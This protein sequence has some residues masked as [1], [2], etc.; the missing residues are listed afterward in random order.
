MR[1]SAIRKSARAPF[2]LEVSGLEEFLHLL[3]LK[4]REPG[5]AKECLPRRAVCVAD[6]FDRHSTETGIARVKRYVRAS[7]AFHEDLISIELLSSDGFEHP[8]P[9]EVRKLEEKHTRLLE[10]VRDTIQDRLAELDGAMQFPLIRGFLHVT[11][12][13]H[14]HRS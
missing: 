12:N 3:E 1:E 9:E 2:E 8:D 13:P 10:R 5:A 11:T 4:L 6:M 7:F 14:S